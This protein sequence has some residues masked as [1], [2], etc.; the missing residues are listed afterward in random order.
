[1]TH[2]EPDDDLQRLHD[3][4]AELREVKRQGDQ[5]TPLLDKLNRHVREN[6]FADRLV[7]ALEYKFRRQA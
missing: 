3:A 5:M 2:R 6:A 4:E 7:A 1:M